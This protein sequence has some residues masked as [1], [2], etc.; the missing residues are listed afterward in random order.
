MPYVSTL[1]KD[2][3]KELF[4]AYRAANIIE[5]IRQSPPHFVPIYGGYMDNQSK[6]ALASF[7]KIL[8]ML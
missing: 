7:V 3:R 1:S 2:V 6:A 5:K 8:P 4:A